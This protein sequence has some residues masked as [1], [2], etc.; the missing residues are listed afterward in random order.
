M[1]ILKYIG[2]FIKMML[3]ACL[4]SLPACSYLDVIPPAQADYEDTMKDEATTLA[5]LFTAYSYVADVNPFMYTNIE[6]SADEIV[7]PKDWGIAEQEM[8]FG[9]ISA[10][11]DPAKWENIYNYI[12]Y[13]HYFTEQLEK[14][15]PVGVTEEDKNQYRAK[16]IFWKPTIIFGHWKLLALARSFRPKWTRIYQKRKFPDVRISIIVSIIL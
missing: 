8:L 10:S 9:N 4:L 2:R 16:L 15:N 13:V 12:G 7:H 11:S 3:P 6:N 14:L 5:F 1:E